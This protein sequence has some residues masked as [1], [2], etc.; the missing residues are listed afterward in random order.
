MAVVT[1]HSGVEPSHAVAVPDPLEPARA[2]RPARRAATTL[3]SS[4]DAVLARR[5]SSSTS[6]PPPAYTSRRPSRLARDPPRAASVGLHV[7]VEAEGVGE[8]AHLGLVDVAA[9][10]VGG[11]LAAEG[12]RSSPGT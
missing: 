12:G 7:A 2:A 11:G 9:E 3:P 1:V 5:R 8:R 4:R 10:A 6:A